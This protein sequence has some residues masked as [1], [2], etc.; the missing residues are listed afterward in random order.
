MNASMKTIVSVYFCNPL[1]RN[2]ITLPA[3]KEKPK[4]ASLAAVLHNITMTDNANR[5]SFCVD[6]SGINN[7][8][9]RDFSVLFTF[10]LEK[11]VDQVAK[12]IKH[13]IGISDD[14]VILNVYGFTRGGAAAF[15]LC[16][17]LNNIISDWLTINVVCIDPIG[18]N[19]IATAKIDSLFNW[20]VT[21]T[22]Q[23]A[24]LSDCANLQN[25]LVL[26][27]PQFTDNP[28]IGESAHYPVLPVY[29][30]TCKTEVDVTPGLSN[31]ADLSKKV[32]AFCVD[33]NGRMMAANDESVIVFHRVVEFMKQSGTLFQTN[34]V[35]LSENL[36]DMVTG[37]NE[38]L[39]VIYHRLYAQYHV[40]LETNAIR[41]MHLDNKIYLSENKSYLNV[42]HQRLFGIHPNRE[43]CIFSVEKTNP[44]RNNA[45]LE[46]STEIQQFSFFM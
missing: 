16:K 24:D 15:L 44:Q 46:N 17:K 38:R 32:T 34:D 37:E 10:N 22:N 3:K 30:I 8:D 42:H 29:P 1:E 39:H 20:N 21:L 9:I 43:D 31:S 27:T 45:S 41:D 25:M 28:F 36:L 2:F 12:K 11:Q 4:Y 14:E 23:I 18:G 13:I 5:Y 6:G 19:L 40:A 35:S 33:H 7:T 26:F